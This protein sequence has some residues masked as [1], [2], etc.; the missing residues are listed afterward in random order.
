ML[1]D[2]FPYWNFVPINTEHS[3][4]DSGGVFTVV[5]MVHPLI[6]VFTALAWPKMRGGKLQLQY[7]PASQ[8]LKNQPTLVL[9]FSTA[10]CCYL[11]IQVQQNHF[12]AH[13][14]KTSGLVIAWNYPIYKRNYY[15]YY[16]FY[17]YYYYFYYYYFYYYYY[18]YPK[19]PGSSKLRM[20]MGPKYLS[21]RFGD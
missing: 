13:M 6:L 15:Y 8:T 10:I 4:V 20:V 9:F 11:A 5:S 21:F 3:L 17:Y 19:D 12:R 1:S 18:Y 2:V 16:Y 14:F 7:R